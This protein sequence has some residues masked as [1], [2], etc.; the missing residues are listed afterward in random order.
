MGIADRRVDLDLPEV[1]IDRAGEG[2]ARGERVLEIESGVG[3]IVDGA[4]RDVPRR[5][6]A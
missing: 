5:W 6:A 3:A 4:V 2:E 1:G